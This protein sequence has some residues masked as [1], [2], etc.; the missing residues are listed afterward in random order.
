MNDSLKKSLYNHLN[1]QQPEIES[2]YIPMLETVDRFK[3][4]WKDHIAAAKCMWGLM[5]EREL[6]RTEGRMENLTWLL[7][8]RYT[9]SQYDAKKQ[10]ESFTQKCGF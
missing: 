6:V 1:K 10:V 5:S 4:T 2:R 8:E 3:G 9:M 7:Q